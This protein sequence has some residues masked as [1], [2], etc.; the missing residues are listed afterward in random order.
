MNIRGVSDGDVSKYFKVYDEHWQG[1]DPTG[2]QRETGNDAMDRVDRT[3]QASCDFDVTSTVNEALKPSSERL[4][5]T[6]LPTARKSSSTPTSRTSAG[7][8]AVSPG[9]P[10]TIVN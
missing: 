5:T 4:R 2:N 8:V 6:R 10:I 9:R 7:V 1:G 3:V